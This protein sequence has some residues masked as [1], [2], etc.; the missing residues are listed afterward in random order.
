MTVVIS[1]VTLQVA[2]LSLLAFPITVISSLG[3]S[4]G[5]SLIITMCVNIS[6][7]PAVL[8]T[9]PDFFS[10]S[11]KRSECQ[12]DPAQ[13]QTQFLDPTNVSLLPSEEAPTAHT[14]DALASPGG[15][16][17]GVARLTTSF[18]WNVL[19]LLGALGAMYPM[20][21]QV[22]Q[23]RITNTWAAAMARGSDVLG[24][25]QDMGAAF[26]LGFLSPCVPYTHTMCFVCLSLPVSLSLW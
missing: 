23:G 19:V 24:V 22:D 7:L 18:P 16:W 1:S 10:H 5:V 9:F 2:F 21:W 4:C 25:F 20:A 15:V 11:A 14:N 13:R 17:S 3:L 12:P 6:L 26:G 8:L